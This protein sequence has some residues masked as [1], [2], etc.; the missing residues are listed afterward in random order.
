MMVSK[1][2]FAHAPGFCIYCKRNVHQMAGGFDEKIKSGEDIEY[3]HRL[4]KNANFGLIRAVRI[5]VSVRRLDEDGRF[6]ISVKLYCR[7]DA[8]CF[9]GP[10][11][12]DIF[13][14][15]FEY[16]AKQLDDT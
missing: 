8:S 6:N 9:S 15:K 13:N 10:A 5:P 14:Y 11:C 12:S 16:S 2:F 7:R 4:S 3:V 1:K